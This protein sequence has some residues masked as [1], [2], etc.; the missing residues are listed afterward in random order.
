MFIHYSRH[1]RTIASVTRLTIDRQKAAAPRRERPQG[2]PKC[3]AIG[4]RTEQRGSSRGQGPPRIR[5]YAQSPDGSGLLRGRSDVERPR[6]QP[7]LCAARGADRAAGEPEG[8]RLASNPI[9]CAKIVFRCQGCRAARC[10][11]RSAPASYSA[12]T[13]ASRAGRYGSR[14]RTPRSRP[15]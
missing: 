9:R 7:K 8:A 5:S 1:L 6:G 4:A 11:R 13:R 15:R 12:A 10:P 2:Q 3:C 14:A